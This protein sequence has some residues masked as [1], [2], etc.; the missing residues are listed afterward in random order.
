MSLDAGRGGFQKKTE[1]GASLPAS[2]SQNKDDPIQKKIKKKLQNRTSA[3][4]NTK[5]H[6]KNAT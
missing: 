3:H 1:E 4:L 5:G 6:E 2:L